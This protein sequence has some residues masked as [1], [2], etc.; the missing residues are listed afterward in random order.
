MTDLLLHGLCGWLLGF[1]LHRTGLG[2]PRG[3]RDALSLRRSHAL[4]SALALMG[5][6]L[7]VTALLGYLAVIDVD[8][9]EVLPLSAGVLLGG[10]LLGIAAALA[11]F[12]PITAL[13]GLGGGHA[14]EAAATLLGFAA[15]SLLTPMLP[16]QALH[17]APPYLHATLFRVTLDEPFL[18]GGGFGALALTGILL[19][20]I[21][22]CIPA[23]RPQPMNTPA[24][25]T[26]PPPDAPAPEELPDEDDPALPEPSGEDESVPEDPS[27]E[28][29]HYSETEYVSESEDQPE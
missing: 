22:L 26:P 28:D 7:A 25:E 29:E 8:L 12:T 24:P 23:P 11:G 5:Y 6:A 16:L 21:A 19:V 4:R 14:L 15:A 3:L 17:H 27:A 20:I 10:T 1:T 13:T 2:R 18:L 9:I